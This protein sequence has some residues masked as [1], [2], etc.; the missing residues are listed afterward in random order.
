MTL[1]VNELNSLIKRHKV[2][3][4]LKKTKTRS[5]YMLPVGDSLQVEDI[6]RLKVKRWKKV[7]HASGNQN[8]AGISILIS[9]KI[10]YEKNAVIRVKEED[11]SITNIYAHNIGI[12]QYTRKTLPS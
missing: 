6:Y 10:D 2:A 8:K 3:G 12:Y 9:D 5:N 11:T 4:L 7:F 1:N